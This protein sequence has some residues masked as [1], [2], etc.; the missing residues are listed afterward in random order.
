MAGL[1]LYGSRWLF[2]LEMAGLSLYGSRWLF[3]LEMAVGFPFMVH[4]G[5]FVNLPLLLLK[6]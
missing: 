1:S 3:C 2:C 5:F 4:A 6:Q